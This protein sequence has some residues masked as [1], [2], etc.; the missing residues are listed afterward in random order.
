M[1]RRPDAS[2]N[3]SEADQ[4]ADRVGSLLYRL[5]EGAAQGVRY[6]PLALAPLVAAAV[7]GG[8]GGVEGYWA[9]SLLPVGV[10]ALVFAAKIPARR[11]LH[12]AAALAAGYVLTSSFFGHIGRHLIPTPYVAGLGW[13][14][15]LSLFS[16]SAVVSLRVA[17]GRPQRFLLVLGTLMAWCWLLFPAVVLAALPPDRPASLAVMAR[18]AAEFP[19]LIIPGYLLAYMAAVVLAAAGLKPGHL[20]AP[21]EGA[22]G[23]LNDGRR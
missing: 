21:T 11:G 2:P 16:A 15:V 7:P 6:T 3:T 20:P 23:R 5:R 10:L 18:V 22:D 12:A 17:P 14:A 19:W 9:A 4:T 13:A 8:R 1:S